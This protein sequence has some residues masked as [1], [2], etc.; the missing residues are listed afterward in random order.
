MYSATCIPALG[1]SARS[2]QKGIRGRTIGGKVHRDLLQYNGEEVHLGSNHRVCRGRHR[3]PVIERSR[4]R[5]RQ[6]LYAASRSYGRMGQV[7][8]E[9][10][11]RARRAL[12][13]GPLYFYTSLGSIESGCCVV[14]RVRS[15]VIEFWI[16]PSRADG[17][18]SPSRQSSPC[19]HGDE[20]GR[21]LSSSERRDAGDGGRQKE[22]AV[23]REI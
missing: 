7:T 10:R 11:P 8:E 20:G 1:V 17:A 2:L 23:F 21:F 14:G 15:S 3:G 18:P 12:R 16:V 4:R 19:E 6:Q 5:P 13:A 22:S 9:C